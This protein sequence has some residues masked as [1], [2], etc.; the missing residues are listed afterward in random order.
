MKEKIK[1]EHTKKKK[2]WDKSVEKT[3][4]MNSL[5]YE[6]NIVEKRVKINEGKDLKKVS[7]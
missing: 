7:L 4:K 5:V 2:K 6:L 3:I 1:I